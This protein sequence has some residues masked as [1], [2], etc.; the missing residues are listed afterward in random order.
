[1]SPGT[2]YSSFSEG[3]MGDHPPFTT[4]WLLLIDLLIDW[5]RLI[6]GVCMWPVSELLHSDNMKS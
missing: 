3:I 6:L 2:K 1:M 5:L 4:S